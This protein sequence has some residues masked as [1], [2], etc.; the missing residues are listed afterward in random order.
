MKLLKM[1]FIKALLLPIALCVTANAI[2]LRPLAQFDFPAD[3]TINKKVED[4]KEEKEWETD[5]ILV[6][7][8]EFLFSAEFAPIRYGFG[9]GYRSSQKDGNSTITPAFLPIWGNFSFGFYNKEWFAVPYLVVR[10]GAMAALSSRGCWWE[11]PFHFFVNAGLGFILPY[12]FGLEVNYD[13]SSVQK[14]F[15]DRNTKF[16]V[17]SGRLGLQLSIGFSLTH[18]RK[19]TSN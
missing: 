3:V 7:G 12:N 6:G 15:D 18:E 16:R 1:N 19:Y 8:L 10:G 17:S 14:S 2:E 13:Y 5:H 9:L 11:R 4:V